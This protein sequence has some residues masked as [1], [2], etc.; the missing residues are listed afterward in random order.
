MAHTT[1]TDALDFD[2]NLLPTIGNG[3]LDRLNT[4][5]ESEPVFWSDHQRG[6]LITRHAD[7]L[8]G[9]SGNLPLSTA[10]M[11]E[12]LLHG[13]PG[14]AKAMPTLMSSLPHWII[15]SDP[16][17]HTRM[18]RLMGKAVNRKVVES[19]RP[20]AQA[21][22][23][24]LLDSLTN[25]TDVEC[26]EDVARLITGKTI[27]RLLG[28]PQDYL[29][30][31]KNWATDVVMALAVVNA[32]ESALDA[33][34]RAVLEMFELFKN[35]IEKRRTNPQEDIFTGLVQAVD[36]GEQLTMEEMVGSSV[37]LLLAGHDT[38]LNSIVMGVEALSRHAAHRHWLAANPEK[39]DIAAIEI[40]RYIAMSGGQSRI[41]AEDFEWHGKQIKKNDVVYLMI[42]AANRDPRVFERPEDLNFARDNGSAATFAPG[43]HHCIGHMLGRMQLAEF[44]S[45]AYVRF[46]QIKVL[47]PEIRY[48]PAWAFRAIPQLKVRFHPRQL[49]K[50]A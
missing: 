33:G 2:F 44:F 22:I 21:N 18:R 28:V 20:F 23:D 26:N 40:S 7:V 50:A 48:A 42:A 46:E 47:E 8:A 30:Q 5:R 27:L 9:F 35:E 31:L 38:T 19:V 45:R 25:R 36:G 11:I 12:A 3:W 6:W 14:R 29:G 10:R 43:V 41:A 4:L 16:P 1:K 17:A 39:G 32:P 34:E 49:K 37:V 15:N 24:T 13:D